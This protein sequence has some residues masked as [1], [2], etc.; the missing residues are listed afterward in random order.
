ML[1]SSYGF[2]F[3]FLPLAFARYFALRTFVGKS[4]TSFGWS[5]HRQN[6]GGRGVVPET[7]VAPEQWR[8]MC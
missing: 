8:M 6:V 4:A 1:F 7:L 2:V 5:A 3:A